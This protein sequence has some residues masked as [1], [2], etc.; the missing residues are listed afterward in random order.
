MYRHRSRKFELYEPPRIVPLD[1]MNPA[2]CTIWNLLIPAHCTIALEG[3]LYWHAAQ[4]ELISVVLGGKKTY[5][6]RVHVE[7]LGIDGSHGD[8]VVKRWIGAHLSA[9]TDNMCTKDDSCSGVQ[10]WFL[11]G[12][13]RVSLGVLR[14]FG[15]YYTWKSL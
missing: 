14:H 8:K 10:E 7:D 13:P 3:E 9:H 2:D 6:S 15:C 12:M 4:E 11:R 1:V 5:K